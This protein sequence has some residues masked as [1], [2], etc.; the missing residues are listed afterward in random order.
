MQTLAGPAG[1]VGRAVAALALGATLGATLTA[2][3]PPADTAAPAT[4]GDV[5]TLPGY[6]FALQWQP[7]TDDRGVVGYEVFE[8]GRLRATVTEPSHVVSACCPLPPM[9][10]VFAVR[11]VDAA[12][13]RSPFGF[14][15]MGA[16]GTQPPVP[17]GNLRVAGVDAGVLRLTWDEPAIPAHHA[18]TAAGYEISVDGVR[19]AEVSGDTARLRAPRR[20]VHTFAVRAFNAAGVRA[21]PVSIR[22]RAR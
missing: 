15:P 3:A 14:H 1:R 16:F 22:H 18:A 11:A 10:F 9:V 4:P 13:N 7:S 12:G 5:R 20:G 8:G 19:V 2:A 6:G 17:P 21:D